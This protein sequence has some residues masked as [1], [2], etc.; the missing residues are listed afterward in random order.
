MR[1]TPIIQCDCAPAVTKLAWTTLQGRTNSSLTRGIWTLS[2]NMDDMTERVVTS[3]ACW[4][5]GGWYGRGSKW[6]LCTPKHQCD[7]EEGIQD[8]L[9]VVSCCPSNNYSDWKN[10][11]CNLQHII[12][13]DKRQVRGKY[14][15]SCLHKRHVKSMMKVF[16]AKRRVRC[17]SSQ[18]NTGA[19]SGWIKS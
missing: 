16:T 15:K 10:T 3:S 17:P 9:H 19:R 11:Q 7:N 5:L 4:L 2:M 18:E 14:S 8:Q 12:N 6:C 13:M 1:D